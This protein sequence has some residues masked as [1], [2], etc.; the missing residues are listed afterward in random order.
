LVKGLLPGVPV[1][2]TR[3]TEISMQREPGEIEP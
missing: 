3:D 2:T 1:A